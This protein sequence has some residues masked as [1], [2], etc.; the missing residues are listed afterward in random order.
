MVSIVTMTLDIE[1]KYRMVVT[2]SFLFIVWSCFSSKHLT[3]ALSHFPVYLSHNAK[4][5]INVINSKLTQ[6]WK[7]HPKTI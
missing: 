1:S 2:R 3:P 5:A 6:T 7:K 4:A